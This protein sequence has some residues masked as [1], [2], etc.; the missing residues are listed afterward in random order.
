MSQ[1]VSNTLSLRNQRWTVLGAAR[2]GLAA[3]EL[4]AARGADV[5]VSDR[6]PEETMAEQK[7]VLEKLGIA[8]EFGRHSEKVFECDA[9]VISPGIPSDAPVVRAAVAKGLSVI[10]ELELASRFCAAPIIAVTGTNGKTTTTVLIGELL[11]RVHDD[12]IVA[13]NIGLPFAKAVMRAP[14]A[15][16]AVLEVSSFQLDHVETFHPHIAVITNI[17]PDHLGRYGMDFDRYL[18]SKQR[19]CTN[20]GREDFVVFN[21]DDEATLEAV[22][23]C[24]EPAT[25]GFSSSRVLTEGAFIRGDQLVL[26]VRER[27]YE[28]VHRADLHVPGRH[29]VENV[30]AAA[31]AA[32]L[33]GVPVGDIQQGCA[34]FRGVPHRMEN[35]R[36]I[37]GVDYVNDSK[38]TNVASVVVAL[39]SY[40]RPIILI[41]GGEDKGS[42]YEPMRPLVKEKVKAMIVLGEAAPRIADAF[43]DVTRIVRVKDLG[44]AVRTARSLAVH[45]D[46]VLLSPACASFDMFDNFEHR[47][48]VFREEVRALQPQKVEA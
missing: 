35:V 4:L 32:F 36:T 30:L 22:G 2:S 39:E 9:M 43:Q 31:T 44:E 28:I 12:V 25:I 19:I 14:N 13:G 21:A 17:T 16:Y 7:R 46:V 10:S 47:G 23:R 20:Q 8:C 1:G 11:R 24:V 45:G 15:G 26:K 5:F 38:A 42:S 6:A 3:A 33:A 40:A 18:A 48:D 27:E 37:D 41:A 34:A 29:N